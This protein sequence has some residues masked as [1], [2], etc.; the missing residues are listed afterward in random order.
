M[1]RALFSARL[2]TAAER[3][4][5]FARNF[6]E[7]QLPDAIVFRVHFN[8]S[9]DGNATAEFKLFPADSSME[10]ALKTKEISLEGA[11]DVLWRG[12]L[13]PQWVDVQVA[14]ESGATTIVDLR[15][16]GRFIADESR[17]YYVWTDVAPFGVKG[18]WLPPNYVEGERFSIYDQPSCWTVADLRRVQR[19]ATKVRFLRLHGPGFDDRVVA[20]GLSF[21]NLTG[22][23]LV[24]ASLRGHGLRGLAGLPKLRHL[25]LD[26][27]RVDDAFSLESVPVMPALERMSLRLLPLE[28]RGAGHF[29]Q[30]VPSLRDLTL[31]STVCT[32]CRDV[33]SIPRLE[34]LTLEF[35][36][37]P[38]WVALPGSLRGLSLHL[39]KIT[40]GEIERVLSECPPTLGSLGLRGTPVSNSILE[41][42]ERFPRL[43]YLDAADTKITKPVLRRFASA[44]PGF[45]CWPRLDPVPTISFDR[46]EGDLLKAEVEALVNPVNCVGV[47][48]KGL[49][50][51]FKAAFPEVFRQYKQACKR[52]EVVPGRM[53][54]VARDGSP[55]YVV[56]FPTKNHW[57]DKS[58]LD[59]IRAGLDA[60][61]ADVVRLGIRSVA[62]PPVGCG[63]G[64][65][66][67]GAVRPLIMD[68]FARVDGVQRSLRVV[69]FE[70]V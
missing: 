26:C 41:L 18:P 51:Q 49:A 29:G 52:G 30:A 21:P 23:D 17:L 53:H 56:N 6:I 1:E 54:I 9:Y 33:L 3:A 65:L 13:V 8:Q 46:G 19:N 43:K 42:L 64:G 12:G 36:S 44:R 58:K 14:G 55:R 20:E 68:A 67:W 4:R 63:L 24:G 48:G 11:I 70:P 31:V 59:D 57:R 27:G 66:E 37:M 5:D 35:P 60:L 28:L 7:E 10:L 47:M 50:A 15:A 39:P 32:T 40:D 34:Q 69:I 2:R 61:A 16:C 22:L 25:S 38:P 62:I 45:R